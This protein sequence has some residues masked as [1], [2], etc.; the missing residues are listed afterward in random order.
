MG[1]LGSIAYLRPC[2]EADDAFVYDVFCTTWESEV[3]ALPNQNLAQ[4]VLRI[5]HIAQERRFAGRYPGHQ[6]YIVLEDGQPAGRLYVHETDLDAARRRPHPDAAVPRPRPRHPDLPATCSATPRPPARRSRCG[7]SA[8]TSAPRCSTPRLGF[9]LVIVDDLDNYFEWAPATAATKEDASAALTKE[10]ASL[11]ATGTVATRLRR[12][13]LLT[14]TGDA[15]AP[16]RCPGPAPWSACAVP[17]RSA[18]R[19]QIDSVTPSRPSRTGLVEPARRRCPAPSSRTRDHHPVADL[20]DEHPG[21]RVRPD[22]PRRRCPG[23]RVRRP[24]SSS[25]TAAGSSTGCAGAETVTVR[26]CSRLSASARSARPVTPD[27]ATARRRPAPGPAAR[28][29]APPPA[30]RAPRRR[31]PSSAPRRCTRASTWST[32]SCTARASRARSAIA[33]AI[34]SASARASVA[35]RISAGGVA[36][37]TGG[38][39]QQ[40]DVAPGRAGAVGAHRQVEQPTSAPRRARPPVQPR[41]T[42]QAS[43]AAITQNDGIVEA[44]RS[45]IASLCT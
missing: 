6:R 44:C 4:H 26:D 2:T 27:G 20:L 28:P 16:T 25:T 3:A 31:R 22:V 40:E 5:Q 35:S 23:R 41:S 1:T 33:A 45:S 30:G 13:A 24:R 39:E 34:R 10:D 43:T 12:L 36:D 18:I 8:A 29:P 42:A 19:P 15:P 7:S 32:P 9:D 37:H 14:S 38:Q 11:L 21:R 17:P